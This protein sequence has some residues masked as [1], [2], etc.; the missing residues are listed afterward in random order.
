MKLKPCDASSLETECLYGEKIEIINE[1]SEWFYCILLTDNYRGWIRKQD[2]GLLKVATHRVLSIRTFVFAK[3]NIKSNILFYLP[4]G[5]N[6]A[7]NE[8]KDNWA[9]ISLPDQ[10]S[11]TLGYVPSKHLI[12]TNKTVNDWVEFAENFLEI[13]YKWGGRNSIGIDCSALLQLSYQT[14]GENISRNSIDQVKLKKKEIH[15][16][17]LLDRGFVVFWVGHVAIMVDK[18]NCIHANAF[19]LKTVIEPLSNV[20]KRMGSQVKIKKMCNFNLR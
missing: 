10:Q 4:M 1:T 13:P 18:L 9:E 19:H 14:Y 8:I 2:I 5:A 11:L 20:I 16:I 7:V 6:L 15:D 3:Q 17:N 12:E